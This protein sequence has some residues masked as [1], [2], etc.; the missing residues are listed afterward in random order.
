MYNGILIVNKPEGVSSHGAV[1]RLR[2]ILGEKKIGHGGTLD[3]MAQGVLPV[4]IGRATR[5]SGL[6]QEGGKS[7]LAHVRFGISTDTQDTTGRVLTQSGAAPE[8][9]QIKEALSAFRGEIRQIPPMYSALSVGGVRLY[10]LARQGEQIE[11]EARTVTVYA[12]TLGDRLENGDWPLSIDC[13]KGLYVRTLIDDLGKALGCGAAMSAL[14]RTRAGDFRLEDALTLGQIEALHEKNEL[15]PHILRAD[16]LF[17][18]LPARTVPDEICA[19]LKNGQHIALSLSDGKARVYCGEE[20]V[21]I[22]ETTNGISKI[23]KSFY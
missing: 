3:P 20:F 10:K 13:S 2:R 14:V 9:A 8:R 5:A 6:L 23:E 7:Y 22:L 1:A 21:G 11:R 16:C 18:D 4:F 12:L 15:S 19:R 17:S